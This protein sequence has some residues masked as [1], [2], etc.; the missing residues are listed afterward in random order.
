M[1]LKFGFFTLKQ[2]MKE[3]IMMLLIKT[4]ET[5]FPLTLNSCATTTMTIMSSLG[6]DIFVL[7]VNFIQEGWCQGMSQHN[8]LKHQTQL[9]KL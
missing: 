8:F 2:L 1:D 7:I 4:M 9:R 3:R 6:F 5:Y